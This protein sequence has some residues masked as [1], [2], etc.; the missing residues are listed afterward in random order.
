MSD[1]GATHSGVASIEGGLDMNMPGGLGAYGLLHAPL[2]DFGGNITLGVNNGTIDVT[3]LDDMV[4]RIMTPYYFH[5]QDIDF[6]TVDPSSADLQTFLPRSTCM[7][8]TLS[9]NMKSPAND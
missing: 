8:S 6:P 4:T 5:G 1:W 9:S 2:S 3:R 7:C